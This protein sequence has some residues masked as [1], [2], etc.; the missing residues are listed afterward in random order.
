MTCTIHTCYRLPRLER[1]HSQS[2]TTDNR[3]FVVVVFVWLHR[4]TNE[5][6]EVDNDK[7]GI[8]DHTGFRGM[9][10]KNKNGIT[11]RNHNQRA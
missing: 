2:D 10:V 3:L 11:V 8:G 6:K 4:I 9:Y 1:M 5:R 7:R